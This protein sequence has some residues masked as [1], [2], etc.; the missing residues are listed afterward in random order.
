MWYQGFPTPYYNQTHI[1]L[2][3]RCRAFV[4]TEIKPHIEGWIRNKQEYPLA[5]H[6]KLF[7]AGIGGMLYAPEHGGTRQAHHDVRLAH[8]IF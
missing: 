1:E 2:R 8:E 4:E 6:E 3:D 7:K 5:L